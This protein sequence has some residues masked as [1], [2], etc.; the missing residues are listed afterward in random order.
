MHAVFCATLSIGTEQSFQMRCSARSTGKLR[1][2]SASS[3]VISYICP[4][5]ALDIEFS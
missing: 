2:R 3:D 5:L 1:F 4:G